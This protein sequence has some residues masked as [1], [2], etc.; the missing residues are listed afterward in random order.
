MADKVTVRIIRLWLKHKPG[1]RLRV[2]AAVARKLI[3][4]GV[5]IRDTMITETLETH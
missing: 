4:R 5:A 2:S 1:D 3:E